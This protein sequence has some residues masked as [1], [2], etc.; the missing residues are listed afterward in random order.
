MAELDCSRS[1]EK[2]KIEFLIKEI[3]KLNLK[4]KELEHNDNNNNESKEYVNNIL[5]ELTKT[6]VNWDSLPIVL[7]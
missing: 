1:A 2:N 3:I 6:D 7:Y 5:N 4:I